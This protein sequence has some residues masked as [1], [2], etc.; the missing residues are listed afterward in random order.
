MEAMEQIYYRGRKKGNLK[1]MLRENDKRRSAT[2]KR[3]KI[4]KERKRNMSW[5]ERETRTIFF[6][7]SFLILLLPLPSIFSLNKFLSK[8]N[9]IHGNWRRLCKHT[10]LGNEMQFCIHF[11]TSLI[12]LS[13]LFML[14]MTVEAAQTRHK[15]HPSISNHF[16]QFGFETKLFSNSSK[17]FPF[18]PRETVLV[19][20]NLMIQTRGLEINI[21]F[22]SLYWTVQLNLLMNI[23]NSL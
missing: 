5:N 9:Q 15:F 19:V 20:F 17:V 4:K 14:R 1:S 18:S 7:F 11:S 8:G 2:L 6:F 21:I 22:S 3:E 13:L 12:D 16:K 23:S 10:F